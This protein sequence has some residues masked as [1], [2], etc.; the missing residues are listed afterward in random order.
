MN[1][2]NRIYYA[3]K[4]GNYYLRFV[5]DVRVTFCATLNTYIELLFKAEEINSVAVD[6]RTAAAVDSTTL[7]LL[8]KLALYV[9][10][11]ARI[12]PLLIVTDESMIRLL[13][14]MGLDEIFSLAQDFPDQLQS[15]DELHLT[16][17]D[18]E[19]AR[20]RVIEAHRTLMKLNNRNMEV[21]AYL[22]LRLEGEAS[23]GK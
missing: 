2:S 18:T 7:G 14:S 22:V 20:T 4:D 1:P 5:G 11:E 17:A 13:Q 8:A 10:R 12:R 15:L 23:T 19:T 21:F 6:L 9:N 3:H 16:H